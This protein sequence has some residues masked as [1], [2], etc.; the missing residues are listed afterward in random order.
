M[1]FP[2]TCRDIYT[3]SS[4]FKGVQGKATGR[5]PGD[6]V[7]VDFPL[8][9]GVRNGNVAT[10][11]RAQLDTPHHQGAFRRFVRYFILLD[12][13]HCQKVG[14]KAVRP[15][16]QPED[17]VGGRAAQ[18]ARLHQHHVLIITQQH[19]TRIVGTV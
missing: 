1:Y 11:R 4:A 16:T 6:R 10:A 3:T 14:A 18:Q 19:T 17:I 2:R 13:D 5:G 9:E 12:C 8:R 7:R 15:E